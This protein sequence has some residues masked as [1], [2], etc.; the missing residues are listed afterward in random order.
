MIVLYWETLSVEKQDKDTGE[1]VNA[2]GVISLVGS[3]WSKMPLRKKRKQTQPLE[4][5]HQ[6]MDQMNVCRR[7]LL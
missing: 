7:I 4:M 6:L 1:E 2:W 3:S 5:E